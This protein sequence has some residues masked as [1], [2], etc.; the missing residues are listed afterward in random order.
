VSDKSEIIKFWESQAQKF[1][2]DVKAVNFDPL[3]EELEIF[4][5][6]Q[7][8]A[9]QETICDIGC[10]NGRT[11][12]D[13]ALKKPKCIFYGL[14]FS[15]SMIA[16]ANEKKASLNISNINFFHLD[17]ILDNLAHYIDI[18]FD[19]I[20]TKRL[21]IN[22]KGNDKLRAINNINEMLKDNG[23]Y[24]MIECFLEPLERINIIRNKLD[25]SEIKVKYFNEYLSYEFL[26]E[27]KS[28]FIVKEK[29][30]FESLYYFISRVFNAYIS[31]GEPDYYA[32]INKLALKLTKMG[33]H[34][35]TGYSPE[36]I[37]LLQKRSTL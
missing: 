14:D 35:M 11:L 28:M 29:I 5:L 6:N 24:M 33:I 8:I 12:I 16:V 3:E 34:N 27:I 30:D 4:F 32:P 25:L 26:D 17:A 2:D 31:N 19:K 36:I 20:I 7:L 22:L 18:K 15:E 13:L 23:I 37:I 9:E 21:L 1:K 10:G